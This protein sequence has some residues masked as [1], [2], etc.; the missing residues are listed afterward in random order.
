MKI[1]FPFLLPAFLFS[2]V[3]A[4]EG[5]PLDLNFVAVDGREVDLTKLRNKVV[6]L[7]FWATWCPP[8][9]KEAPK[10]V[11]AYKKLNSRGLEIVGVSLD[12]SK[13]SLLAFI[14]EHGMTWPQYFDGKGWNN[15]ISSRF[16]IDAIPAKWLIDKQGNVV[17]KNVGDDLEKEVERLLA[18]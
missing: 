13:E 15:E 6:L 17:T 14:K 10:L 9:R 2:M 16:G 4:A 12:Q 11:A 3:L 7:D 5:A 1:C 8:C 18:K